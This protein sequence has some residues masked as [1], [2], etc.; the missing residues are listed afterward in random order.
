M[1]AAWLLVGRTSGFKQCQSEPKSLPG[2]PEPDIISQYGSGTSL[3]RLES[4]VDST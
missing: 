1:H 3:M 2:D 4:E